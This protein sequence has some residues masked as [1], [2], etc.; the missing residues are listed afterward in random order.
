MTGRET[1]VQFTIKFSDSTSSAKGTKEEVQTVQ[2]EKEKEVPLE[3][4]LS[5]ANETSDVILEVEG[6][7]L[8]ANR[9]VLAHYSPVFRKM[10]F[11]D[12]NEKSK[13]IVPLPGKTYDDMVTF[14]NV[15]FPRTAT[16]K[17]LISGNSSYSLFLAFT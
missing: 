7:Q 4:V 13:N 14:F 11:S 5:V 2:Q 8:H 9:A 3:N 17:P 16:S 15:L 10:F 12:F 6:R 1:E